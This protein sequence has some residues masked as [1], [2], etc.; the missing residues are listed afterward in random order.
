MATTVFAVHTNAVEGRED[1]FNDWYD[2]QH[3]PD[4]LAVPGFIRAR[5]YEITDNLATP[6]TKFKYFAIYEIEGDP[7]EAAA[8]LDKAV[9]DGMFLSPAMS[10]DLYATIY[11]PITDW[12]VAETAEKPTDAVSE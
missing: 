1:E 6:L 10:T 5:R 2:D 3:I 7:V 4:V 9:A 12:H 8:A 11:Q